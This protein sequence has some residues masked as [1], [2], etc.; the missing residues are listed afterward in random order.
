MA[1][2]AKSSGTSLG[3]ALAVVRTAKDF[4]NTA[5]TA[6]KVAQGVGAVK[7]TRGAANLV[8]GF[9]QARRRVEVVESHR[10]RIDQPH[11]RCWQS[12]LKA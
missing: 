4:A 11:G 3:T 6:L 12:L 9:G 10:G 8:I 2:R 1:T 7:A 5:N